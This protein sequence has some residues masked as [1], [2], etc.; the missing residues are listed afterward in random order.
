V[1]PARGYMLVICDGQTNQPLHTGFSL[2][3]NGEFLWLLGPSN[4]RRDAVNFGF[5]VTDRPFGRVPDGS[6]NVGAWV[7]C[8]ATPGGKN[9]QAPLGNRNRLIF[10]EWAPSMGT[11]K[12]WFEIYNPETNAVSLANLVFATNVTTITTNRP[13]LTNSWLGAHDYLEFK[14]DAHPEKGIDE[15][16]FKLPASGAKLTLFAPNRTSIIHRVFWP[17]PTGRQGQTNLVADTLYSY[18]WLPDGN[19]NDL[20]VTFPPDRTTPG[21][22]NFL[23][24]DNIYI[25]EILSHSDPPL[26][27]AVELYNDGTNAVNIGGWWLTDDKDTYNKF[28]IPANTII[29]PKGYVAFYEYIGEPGGFNPNG[30]GIFP[31]FSFSSS[32]GDECYLYAT[33][34]VTGKL[35]GFRRGVDFPAAANGVSFGRY[36]TSTGES[37]FVPM[38]SLTFG[39]DVTAADPTN[40]LD[41]FR[42]GTG[43]PN[44]APLVGPLVIN[45]I[46]Y[47]PPDIISGTNIFDNDLDE[48]IQIYNAS[49]FTVKLFDTNVYD[50]SPFGYAYTNTW[51]VRGD[52]DFDFPTNV[53]LAAGQSLLVVNFGLTNTIQLNTFRAKYNVPANVKIFGAYRG[54][55]SNGGGSVQIERPDTP[56]GPNHPTEVGFVPYIRVDKVRYDDEPPWP[57][58][59]DGVRI[60]PTSPN[61]IG[62]VLSRVQP[63]L[64]GGDVTNWIAAVPSA[65]RQTISNYVSMVSSNTVSVNF[66]GLAG[67]G[68]TVQYRDG[69]EAPTWQKLQD[70]PPQ[71]TSGPRQV[72]TTVAPGSKRFYRVLTPIQP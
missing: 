53:S 35:N 45:E 62:Y 47:H 71:S 72:Q 39:T 49:L 65:G 31:S 23:P 66:H 69:L 15:L 43:A 67:S 34:P 36:V 48:Y 60:H 37:D 27:D 54:H 57:I 3:K 5:Q 1:V 16:E 21:K 30:Q 44:A 64:Y 29:Q 38:E 2:G 26:E 32:Q 33:D 46:M 8:T 42:S 12:D 10:N 11:Q 41:E 9:V 6:T 20:V 52:I 40:R 24:I 4:G 22:S 14:C 13:I 55:L 18:G 58:E 70:F 50:Y 59:P 68:Y 7:L 28:H 63:E 56:Q 61:S 17:D 25:N 19:T 51:H